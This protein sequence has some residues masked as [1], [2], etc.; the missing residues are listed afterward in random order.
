[1]KTGNAIGRQGGCELLSVGAVGGTFMEDRVLASGG[2]VR[3]G[4][5][6]TTSK[7]K[8]AG[9]AV[10]GRV[11]TGMVIGRQSGRELLSEEAAGGSSMEEGVLA[12]G[13][14]VRGPACS[15]TKPKEKDAGGVVEG[16]VKTGKVVSQRG[17]RALSS[18]EVVGGSFT[19]VIF[20]ASRGAL[21]RPGL[22]L[23]HV[24][25][26]G[27]RWRRGRSS[28]ERQD[29]RPARRSRVVE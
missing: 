29:G 4:L 12:S 8:V 15:S 24:Q 14:A 25:G 10:E 21:W 17:G 16:R 26:E 11:R 27:R 19:E 2:V 6:S 22:L 20:L 23:D 3:P 28:E 7:E 18:E 1:M 9:G 13:G 5:S